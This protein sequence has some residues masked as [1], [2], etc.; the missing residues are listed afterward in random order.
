MGDDTWLGLFP[1]AFYES[2]PFDS[3][4]VQDLDTVDNG[5][6]DHLFTTIS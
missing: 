3:F 6:I 5:V 1:D 4:N 2:Y